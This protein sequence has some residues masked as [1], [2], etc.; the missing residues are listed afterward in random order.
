MVGVFVHKNK[1]PYV[2]VIDTYYKSY[3]RPRF[4]NSPFLHML[5]FG[6]KKAGNCLGLY[7]VADLWSPDKV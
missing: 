2:R 5:R 4:F 7:G 1:S 3:I 6:G